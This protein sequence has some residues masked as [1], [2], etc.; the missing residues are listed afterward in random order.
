MSSIETDKFEI[1][2]LI[3]KGKSQGYLTWAELN[4]GLPPE[5]AN[6]ERIEDIVVIFNDMGIEKSSDRVECS[7]RPPA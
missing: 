3:S 6:P 5:F 1:K 4:D 7:C 2:A